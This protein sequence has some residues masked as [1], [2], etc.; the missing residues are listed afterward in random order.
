[1]G[2]PIRQDFTFTTKLT[3]QYLKAQ[4]GFKTGIHSPR[5]GNY[6][7]KP[8]DHS[9]LELDVCIQVKNNS[10][11]L[12]AE[13]CYNDTQILKYILIKYEVSYS[14]Q[15]SLTIIERYLTIIFRDR[16]RS[17]CIIDVARNKL[18]W[19]NTTRLM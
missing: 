10:D 11:D 13:S 18:T 2:K 16:I 6:T 8:L 17:V 12:G 7:L 14:R 19:K 5:D 1:M 15:G 3:R 9:V 4:S